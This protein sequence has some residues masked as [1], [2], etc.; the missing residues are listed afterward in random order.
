[1]AERPQDPN[2]LLDQLGEQ[3]S[4][5]LQYSRHRFLWTWLALALLA[6]AMGFTT[7]LALRSA[8]TN[9][10]QT[11]DIAKVAHNEAKVANQDVDDIMKFLKGEEG[12]PGVPGSNGQD[13]SHR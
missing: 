6:V 1:M 3:N 5:V 7:L 13:G 9:L 4:D 8:D 2:E 10:D 11:D 12:I